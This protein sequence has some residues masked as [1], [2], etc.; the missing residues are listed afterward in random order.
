MIFPELEEQCWAFI[1]SEEVF[2]EDTAFLLYKEAKRRGIFAVKDLMIPRIRNFFLILVSSQDFVE[3]DHDE[4]VLLLS[5]NYIAVN[6]CE[7]RPAD[8]KD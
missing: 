2:S 5:S 8:V 1:D 6:W 7:N 3:L 4:I